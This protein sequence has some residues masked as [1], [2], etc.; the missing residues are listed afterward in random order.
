MLVRK[1]TKVIV[2]QVLENEQKMMIHQFLHCRNCSVLSL[3]RVGLI[4]TARLRQPMGY[5]IPQ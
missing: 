3:A 1:A 4:F 2:S 5:L